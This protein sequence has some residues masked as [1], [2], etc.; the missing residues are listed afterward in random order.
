MKTT[1][2][3]LAILAATG[4]V[5]A[6]L[7]FHVSLSDVVF[8]RQRLEARRIRKH[9]DPVALQRWATNMLALHSRDEDF[10]FDPHSTN[11][12]SDILSLYPR[13]PAVV[14][15]RDSLTI[16]W[17]R[18]HPVV[19]VGTTNFVLTNRLAVRWISGVYLMISE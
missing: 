4:V 2:R 8:F 7:W 9:S 16:V 3:W 19:H 5:C 17:G 1:L 10:Y 12:P 11:V 18:G 15:G 6:F 14:A 13:P